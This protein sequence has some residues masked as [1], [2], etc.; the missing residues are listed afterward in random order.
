[1]TAEAKRENGPEGEGHV[2]IDSVFVAIGSLLII[3]GILCNEWLL[4]AL[5]SLDKVV[6]LPNRIMVWTFDIICLFSGYLCI[7]Y[8]SRRIIVDKLSKLHRDSA[9]IVFNTLLLILLV[10]FSLT[11][12]SKATDLLFTRPNL[13]TEKYGV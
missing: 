13:V 10:N 2:T 11:V 1:M 12:V 5:F 7:K 6:S 9:I 3:M 8:R 4:S